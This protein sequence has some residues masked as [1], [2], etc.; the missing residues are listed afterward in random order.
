MSRPAS[1]Q[2]S[3]V[4]KES[5]KRPLY[6]LRTILIR[7]AAREVASSQYSCKGKLYVRKVKSTDSDPSTWEEGFTFPGHATTTKMRR[8][9]LAGWIAE[10]MYR[11]RMDAEKINFWLENPA[12]LAKKLNKAIKINSIVTNNETN[13]ADRTHDDLMAA[14]KLI[15]KG[16]PRI[17]DRAKWMAIRI[18]IDGAVN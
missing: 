3:Q 5:H 10:I 8:I 1:F 6:D 13:I 7:Q 15:K 11:G 4:T 14:I 16:W 18:L 2:H 12:L 17:Q 9:F